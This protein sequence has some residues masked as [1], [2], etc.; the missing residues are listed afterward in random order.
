M[1]DG[2]LLD[3]N[4]LVLLSIPHA[5]WCR[6]NGVVMPCPPTDQQQQE[7]EEQE[8]QLGLQPPVEMEFSPPPEQRDTFAT[9]VPHMCVEQ[10][11]TSMIR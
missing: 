6:N 8:N 9:Q 1:S 10:V 4:G 2:V 7:K 11:D 5:D 3:E